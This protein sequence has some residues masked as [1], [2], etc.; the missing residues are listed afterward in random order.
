MAKRKPCRAKRKRST[1]T[2]SGRTA[3]SIKSAGKFKNPK[4]GSG[5]YD[6][7]TSQKQYEKDYFG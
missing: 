6:Y 1:T 5:M 4:K 2:K 3:A 7:M